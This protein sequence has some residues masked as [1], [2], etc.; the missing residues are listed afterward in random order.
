[1][2]TR[3]DPLTLRRPDPARRRLLQRAAASG[4][5]AVLPAWAAFPDKPVR[6]VVP[7]SA[8]GGTDIIARHVAQRLQPRLGQTVLVEN[9]PGADGVIGTDVVAK[10]PPDGSAFV[11]VVASHLINPLVIAKMPYDT[12][13]DMVGVTM[14]AESPLVF[15]THVDVPAR[16]AKELAELI[17]RTP[18]KYSYGSS[19]NMT[20]LVGAMFVQGQKLDAVHVP[21][22]GGGPLMTDVAGG[23]TTLGVTSVLSAKQLMTAGKLKALGITGAKRSTVL[24]EVPT[25]VELGYPQFAEVRT[26]Y[27]LFAPA[28]TPR[29]TLERMQKE[30]A[31][32]IHTP[33]M[34]EILAAQAASPVGNTVA[35]FQEQV[36]RESQFWAGL[37]KSINLRPE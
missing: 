12:H 15:V 25:M 13:R 9:R 21:Y 36:K 27:S 19:E 23:V 28:A 16:N 26:T 7:Y 33:E 35:D 29:E 32:V 5:T 31:A 1:M 10:A 18:G 24:P 3:T 30:V 20:R 11:L 8:G 4:A 14:V 2:R 6:I 17:R 37:A 22:K 34:V